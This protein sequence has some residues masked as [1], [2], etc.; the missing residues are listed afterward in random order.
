MTA[1]N[2]SRPGE[3]LQG[4]DVHVWLGFP[5]ANQDTAL[6]HAYGELLSPEEWQRHALLKFS[7][8]KFAYLY[9]HALL[10]SVLS[11]YAPVEP[12]GWQFLV[13]EHGRPE[14]ANALARLEAL[15]FSLSHT[16]GLAVVAVTQAAPVGV[17]AEQVRARPAPLEV[18]S[19]HFSPRE[20][21]DL[22]VVPE[23]RRSDRFYEYWTLKEAYIKARGLGLSAAL[24]LFSLQFVGERSVRLSVE[25]ALRDDAKSWK[26]W[27]FLPSAD[28]VVA[29]CARRAP[30]QRQH[31]VCRR[32]TPLAG[33]EPFE[34]I[35]LRE[36]AG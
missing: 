30:P 18:A 17:D 1:A 35:G 9:A 4:S 20:V 15:S 24:D 13:G 6:L 10:R 34:P 21:R 5:P 3:R 33:D 32:C 16:Q 26:L 27:Q 19:G 23:G 11:K 12:R 25:P 14:I 8:D 28:H 31:L 36:S 22:H 29:V 2:P 7:G